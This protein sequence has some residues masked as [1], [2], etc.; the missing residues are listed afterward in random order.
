M[1][2]EIAPNWGRGRKSRR[3]RNARNIVS[4]TSSHE[5]TP[6]SQSLQSWNLIYCFMGLRKFRFGIH[7]A[8]RSLILAL[9]YFGVE[10]CSE[11][12]DNC[13]VPF[14]CKT[15]YRLDTDDRKATFHTLPTDQ[16]K[17]KVRIVRAWCLCFFGGFP[18][19]VPT[20]RLSFLFLPRM[21]GVV[22]K[23]PKGHFFRLFS[24]WMDEDLFLA[25]C[26]IELQCLVD[27]SAVDAVPIVFSWFTSEAKRKFARKKASCKTAST[28]TRNVPGEVGDS[29]SVDYIEETEAET[30]LKE[31]Q[32]EKEKLQNENE[33]LLRSVAELKNTQIS[34]EKFRDSDMCFILASLISKLFDVTFAIWTLVSTGKILCMSHL[35][36]GISTSS[37]ILLFQWVTRQPKKAGKGN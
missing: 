17:L 24:K 7:S 31:L 35:V 20:S 1:G 28:A 30:K 8:I 27:G 13:C 25:F 16:K 33:E 12:P 29:D 10:D 11:M 18:R 36:M 26:G 6:A 37:S 19:T 15:G 21:P 4:A 32:R 34:V 5:R 14:C 2:F 23:D 3:W 22:D 9:W